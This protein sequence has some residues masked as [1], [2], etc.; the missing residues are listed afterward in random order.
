M[1]DAREGSP[2]RHERTTCYY[3]GYKYTKAWSPSKKISCRCSKFRSGGLADVKEDMKAMTDCLAIADVAQPA[4]TIWT[5]LLSLV[6][7]DD[8]KQVVIGLSESQL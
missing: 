5:E 1:A 2:G 8:N 4:N 3:K 7:G 6:Y